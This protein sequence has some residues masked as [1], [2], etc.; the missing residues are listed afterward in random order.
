MKR[1]KDDI[2]EAVE[3]YECGIG[4]ENYKDVKAQDIIE[5]FTIEKESAKLT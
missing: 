3:G 4:L 5:A 2:K 1:F